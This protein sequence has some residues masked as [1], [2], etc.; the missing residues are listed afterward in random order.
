LSYRIINVG[1]Q[2][3]R[4][5]VGNSYIKVRG[6]KDTG[7][8]CICIHKILDLP[9]E[10]LQ[11]ALSQRCECCH[12]HNLPLEAQVTPSKIAAFIRANF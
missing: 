8:K 4:Y 2:K 6:P 3:Y 10:V 11:D 12:G 7:S 5:I 1:G 9:A